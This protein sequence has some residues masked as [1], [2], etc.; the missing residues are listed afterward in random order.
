MVT[1]V[2]QGESSEQLA[3]PVN[4]GSNERIA[5]AVIGGALLLFGLNRLSIPALVVTALGGGFLVRGVTGYCPI[6]AARERDERI[7]ARGRLAE[8]ESHGGG[9]ER[10]KRPN[11]KAGR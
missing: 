2:S 8:K 10:G 4:L 11:A 1:A 7:A 3:M 5:S 9:E 6:T